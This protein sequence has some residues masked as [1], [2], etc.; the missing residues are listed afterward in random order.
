VSYPLDKVLP[1]SKERTSHPR[2]PRNI[3]LPKSTRRTSHPEHSKNIRLP[4]R[5]GSTPAPRAPQV[6]MQDTRLFQNIL[7]HAADNAGNIWRRNMAEADPA[8][9]QSG[10]VTYHEQCPTN[11][12]HRR[13]QEANFATPYCHYWTPAALPM[14][15]KARQ[16]APK[17]T[18]PASTPTLRFSL[19]PLARRPH[20]LRPMSLRIVSL[21]LPVKSDMKSTYVCVL[22]SSSLALIITLVVL[23]NDLHG[24]GRI[25]RELRWNTNRGAQAAAITM[26]TALHAGGGTL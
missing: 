17:P 21:S 19:P 18:L 10:G 9:P 3:L 16:H 5:K 14:L 25:S 13:L 11:I 23:P 20:L 1:N 4:N 12:A 24:T 8:P 7:Y 15:C 6:S 26:D 2:H 22:V